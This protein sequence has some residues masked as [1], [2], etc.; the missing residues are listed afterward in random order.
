MHLK[1]FGHSNFLSDFSFLSSKMKRNDFSPVIYVFWKWYYIALANKSIQCHARS[2]SRFHRDHQMQLVASKSKNETVQVVKRWEV[3][4]WNHSLVKPN[5]KQKR[6]THTT[7]NVKQCRSRTASVWVRVCVYV[8]DSS[9]RQSASRQ[10]NGHNTSDGNDS[11]SNA[12][13][14]ENVSSRI[15]ATCTITQM[16][17]RHRANK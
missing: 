10:T 12:Q 9:G 17:K 14:V 6:E 16:S 1:C 13:L 11:E 7:H 3:Q 5:R 4:K 8:Y 15:L 2:K